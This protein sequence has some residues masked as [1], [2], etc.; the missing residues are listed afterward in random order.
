LRADWAVHAAGLGAGLVG[1]VAL[2]VFTA[3]IGGPTAIAAVSVYAVAVLCMFGCSAANNLLERSRH[4]DF[5]RRLDHAAIFVMI[6]G[7]YT[8]I[9]ALDQDGPW[10]MALTACV[11]LVASMGVALKLFGHARS[12]SL[13]TAIYLALGWVPI[14]VAVVFTNSLNLATLRLLLLGGLV[15]SAGISFFVLKRLPF[16]RAIWHSFVLAA[17][18]VQYMAVLTSVSASRPA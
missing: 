16:R 17:A 5:L 7:T 13:S 9:M 8:P 15:Y 10:S 2:V 6:A 1:A 12:V 4:R 3:S 14:T 18:A 11:W